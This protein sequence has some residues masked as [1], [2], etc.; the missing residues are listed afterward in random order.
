[1][2]APARFARATSARLYSVRQKMTFGDLPPFMPLKARMNSSPSITGM[3]ESTITASGISLRQTPKAC[4]PSSTSD[5]LKAR[6]S[7]I[8]LVTLRITLESSAIR[9]CCTASLRARYRQDFGDLEIG[10]PR[11]NDF[12]V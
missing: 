12:I 9:K 8:R 1:M 6:F 2:S 7:Q 11:D 4:S 10:P 3:W 5:T